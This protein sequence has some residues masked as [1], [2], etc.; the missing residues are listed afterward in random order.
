MATIRDLLQQGD[1]L[2]GD[3]PRRDAEILL[4]HCLQ[5]SRA[6]LYA[7][8]EREPEADQAAR[9]ADL[10]A[11][12][13]AGQPVAYL[14]GRREFWSLEL[15]V[16]HNT[17]IPRPETE[18]LVA[19]A[20][21]L[22]LAADSRVLDL[23]TGSGAIALALAQERPA[24]QVT[25][26]DSSPGALAVARENARRLCLDRV[27]LF[28][29]DWFGALRDRRFEL[30]VSNPPYVAAGDPHLQRGDLRFEPPT[31][32]AAGCDGLAAIRG[33][34][35]SAGMHLVPGGWLLLEH[36][37]DQAEPVRDLLQVAGFEAVQTRADLAGLARVSGGRR[38][39]D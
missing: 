7:W 25:A 38:R 23:G 36:G 2:P 1:D 19:W 6:W 33:L 28:E 27:E 8:P 37:A 12:R 16:D 24:W 39:V 3:S 20:L 15:R 5:R 31:A 35:A 17:L 32:L 26:L 29:S 13:R 30:L 11:R 22:D 10:L 4:C 34:T 21:E 9:Y 14:T 18:T